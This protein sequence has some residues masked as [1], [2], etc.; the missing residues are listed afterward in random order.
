MKKKRKCLKCQEIFMS[1]AASLRI[2]TSCKIN[3]NSKN[4][5]NMYSVEPPPNPKSKR[6][7][8]Y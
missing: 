3:N 8:E 5:R 6:S 7:N 2:C 1:R 4:F